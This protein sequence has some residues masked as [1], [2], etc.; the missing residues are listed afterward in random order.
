MI[1]KKPTPRVQKTTTLSNKG[2][3]DYITLWS[4]EFIAR[5]I[6]EQAN[7]KVTYRLEN[8]SR[9]VSFIDFLL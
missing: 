7:V 8:T 6:A 5:L 2:S 1:F 9:S 3:V 4:G